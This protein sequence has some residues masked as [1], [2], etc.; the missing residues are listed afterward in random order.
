MDCPQCC[1]GLA[2]SLLR[3]TCVGKR[4]LPATC[5][6]KPA[7]H[8]IPVKRLHTTRAWHTGSGSR[9]PTFESALRSVAWAAGMML[10]MRIA[11]IRQRLR[12]LGAKPVHE[13]RVLRL[14]SQARRRT[15]AGAGSRISCRWRCARPCPQLRP[16]WT[17]LARLH[18]AHPGEDGSQ[19][20]LVE[21]A[22]GQTVESVLLPRGG[23]CV[24]TQVGCAVGCVF[25][26]TGRDGLLRQLGSA[27]IVA[28]VAL[29][30]RRAPVARWSSWAWASRRTTWTTC[31]RP[32][33][34]WARPGAS[35]T[36]TWSSP[37]WATRA[38]SSGCRWAA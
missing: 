16:S 30:R 5:R 23:L 36:S 22:D 37:P 7:M 3:F 17:A 27:E 1:P 6:V 10:P 38:S 32:S 28:Q 4:R 15:P 35:A 21:L 13:Q 8:R 11:D 19:R 20:L 2:A 25:C 12:A 34:C 14:W 9:D 31:S 29:A 24:S 33:T 18:S 26:M